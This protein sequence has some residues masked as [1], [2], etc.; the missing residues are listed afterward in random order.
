MSISESDLFYRK[1]LTTATSTSTLALAR[2][3]FRPGPR[4]RGSYETMRVEQ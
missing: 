4:A 2:D 1:P 3:F